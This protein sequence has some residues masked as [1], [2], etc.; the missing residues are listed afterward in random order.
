MRKLQAERRCDKVLE[1]LAFKGMTNREVDIESGSHVTF[2]DSVLKWRGDSASL[3]FAGWL[4]ST[5]KI[6]WIE[7]KPGS[8]KSTLM[9]FLAKK[10][11]VVFALRP[12]V[13]PTQHEIVVLKYFAWA[14]GAHLQRNI[15]G[16]L[17]SLLHQLFTADPE[18]L[19]DLMS[20]QGH[21]FPDRFD[22]R[23]T[24]LRLLQHAVSASQCA[25]M[26]FI[27]G[28]D[29]F[30]EDPEDLV[31]FL[32]VLQQ[33]DVKICFASRPDISFTSHFRS[34]CCIRL[35]ELTRP[36]L[37]AYVSARLSGDGKI[38]ASMPPNN[39]LGRNNIWNFEG[40]ITNR[41]QGVFLWARLAL[42]EITLGIKD[43]DDWDT[44]YQLLD[45]V[46]PEVDAIYQQKWLALS[47]KPSS[48]RK[49]AIDLLCLTMLPDIQL[50][51][52]SIA[53]LLDPGRTVMV[54]IVQESTDAL[55][56]RCDK[57]KVSVL[58][59]CAGFIEIAST[60]AGHRDCTEP[61]VHYQHHRLRYIHKTARDFVKGTLKA[62]GQCWLM[63]RK[64]T[65]SQYCR[66]WM[67]MT[68]VDPSA[69]TF[70]L[71]KKK[72]QRESWYETVEW[73]M[74]P[75]LHSPEDA[76]ACAAVDQERLDASSELANAL[77][78][79]DRVDVFSPFTVATDFLGAAVE[80]G[81]FDYVRDK[82]STFSRVPADTLNCL[83]LCAVRSQ[84]SW[85][86]RDRRS[87]TLPI[88]DLLS[89]GA[90]PTETH[91]APTLCAKTRWI[92]LTPWHAYLARLPGKEKEY[93]YMCDTEPDALR[94]FLKAGVDLHEFM[95]FVLSIDLY[96]D[97]MASIEYGVYD[98]LPVW[99]QNYPSLKRATGQHVI[100]TVISMPPLTLLQWLYCDHNRPWYPAFEYDHGLEQP[101]APAQIDL[102]GKGTKESKIQW[103][104]VMKHTDA[105][106][107]LKLIRKASEYAY[108]ND[109]P[110]KTV[111]FHLDPK[112]HYFR[113]LRSLA[114]KLFLASK[115]VSCEPS[116]TDLQ[117]PNWSRH[118]MLDLLAMLHDR[119]RSVKWVLHKFQI[120]RAVYG[121]YIDV[122]AADQWDP[123][124]GAMSRDDDD[125]TSCS[126]SGLEDDEDDYGKD[127]TDNEDS[128]DSGEARSTEM[129]GT[130]GSANAETTHAAHDEDVTVS[131]TDEV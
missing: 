57:V 81:Y 87:K 61:D 11:R 128:T 72:G 130:Q 124:K 17:S 83:L 21:N 77:W 10:S 63:R 107:L 20:S 74:F 25:T 95:P 2:D 71:R 41:A 45:Y 43:G 82:L 52:A 104:S 118:N 60:C 5:D 44:L 55:Q 93:A 42:R 70:S 92:Q 110:C 116:A 15:H 120:P 14:G 91:K 54:D 89:R 40:S 94:A 79:R 86:D 26:A 56:S 49:Q 12:A 53:V 102:I 78:H 105:M 22:D 36:A 113:E 80:M 75:D 90:K 50:L 27:D 59:H 23:S 112:R 76:N 30:L 127:H 100:T 69:P 111:E 8:G 117:Y 28:L 96:K 4:M 108:M 125:I 66:S 9:K 47:R 98:H 37:Y 114:R 18:L 16:M 85:P 58:A 19:P 123:S 7:G 131:D 122:D 6:Y 106:P 29:E 13:P 119:P 34:D 101:S 88:E 48:F 35:Q 62:E 115:R 24:L 32:D 51:Q 33:T 38:K 121:Y 109:G 73:S 126:Y 39:R 1:D 84:P 31:N 103:A 65:W 99:Q 3:S 129:E 64:Q 46:P 97:E 67:V 68:L